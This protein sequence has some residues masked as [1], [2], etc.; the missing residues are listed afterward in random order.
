[1]VL[2]L[3]TVCL[4]IFINE[5][6]SFHSVTLLIAPRSLFQDTVR[7]RLQGVKSKKKKNNCQE[8]LSEQI[9]SVSGFA[10]CYSLSPY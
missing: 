5:F 6:S 10:S 1:M 4:V 8:V 9:I 3:I 2:I 7:T